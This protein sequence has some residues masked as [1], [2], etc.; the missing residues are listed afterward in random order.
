MRPSRGMDDFC[1]RNEKQRGFGGEDGIGDVGPKEWSKGGVGVG[2]ILVR[3]TR[4][5]DVVWGWRSS[6]MHRGKVGWGSECCSWVFGL[7]SDLTTSWIIVPAAAHL[8]GVC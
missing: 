3:H 8:V 2:G 4:P 1:S 7:A 5:K 6:G